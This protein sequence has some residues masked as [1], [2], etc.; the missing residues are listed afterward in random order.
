MQ[1]T[2][3]RSRRVIIVRTGNRRSVR[4]NR[5]SAVLLFF[6]ILRF[7]GKY[8]QSAEAPQIH[9]GVVYRPANASIRLKGWAVVL[10]SA[11]FILTKE[12]WGGLVPV[13]LL[14]FLFFWGL[15]GYFP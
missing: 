11:L 13:A 5:M 9:Q 10:V 15:D 6:P 1:D 3:G 2:G 8:E 7:R 4:V 12:A 14:P